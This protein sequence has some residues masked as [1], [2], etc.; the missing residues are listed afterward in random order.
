MKKMLVICLALM[1]VCTTALAAEWLEGLKGRDGGVANVNGV[2]HDA[3][4]NVV[5]PNA[6][7]TSGT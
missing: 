2:G 1:M 6:F 7:E 4:G 3:A 5:N